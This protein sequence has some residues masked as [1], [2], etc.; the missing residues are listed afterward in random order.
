MRVESNLGKGGKIS[1]PRREIPVR[2]SNLS[3]S[4]YYEPFAEMEFVPVECMYI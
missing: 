3:S 1:S 4:F 2:Y